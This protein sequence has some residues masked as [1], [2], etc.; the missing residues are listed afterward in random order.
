METGI[1]TQCVVKICAAVIILAALYVGV[2]YDAIVVKYC[3][4]ILLAAAVAAVSGIGDLMQVLGFSFVE[5]LKSW[6]IGIM[7]LAILAFVA[8]MYNQMLICPLMIL[9]FAYIIEVVGTFVTCIGTPISGRT[10]G[11]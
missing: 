8:V 10:R 5:I 6:M 7:T 9:A 4:F 11:I 1:K 3:A 2:G